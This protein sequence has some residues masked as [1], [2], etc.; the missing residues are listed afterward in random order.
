MLLVYFLFSYTLSMEKSDL[1]GRGDGSFLDGNVT[2]E[3]SA[4]RRG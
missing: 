4:V 1:I 3:T 2:S